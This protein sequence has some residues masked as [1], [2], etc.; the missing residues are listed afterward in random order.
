MRGGCR[1]MMMMME[2]CCHRADRKFMRP[3]I[4]QQRQWSLRTRDT[5]LIPLLGEARLSY[6][7]HTESQL[8]SNLV[9]CPWLWTDARHNTKA[10]GTSV[11]PGNVLR[12][13]NAAALEPEKCDILRYWR[14]R[15][16]FNAAPLLAALLEDLTQLSAPWWRKKA[17]CTQ[18]NC[19]T[20]G[21]QGAGRVAVEP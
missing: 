15:C 8:F 16:G 20:C 11:K 4:D 9:V 10:W 21:L 12:E 14:T 6:T 5:S 7:T 13:K 3:I 1:M 2:K 17:Q 18:I 19:R